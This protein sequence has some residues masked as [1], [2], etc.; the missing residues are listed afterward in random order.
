MMRIADMIAKRGSVSVID[1]TELCPIFD[2][3]GTAAR[4]AACVIMR[5]M[6][7]L[8]AQHGD[9]IDASLRRTDLID[10]E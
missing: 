2:I 5:L 4:L 8:A 9:V 10:A 1:L 7:A 3:S 6:A